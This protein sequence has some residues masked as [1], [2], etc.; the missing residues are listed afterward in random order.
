MTVGVKEYDIHVPY[1]VVDIEN[2]LVRDL[3]EKPVNQFFINAGIYVLAAEL[4]DYVPSNRPFNI[5]ELVQLLVAEGKTVASFPI[6]EYWLDIGRMP[7]YEQAQKDVRNG[8][9]D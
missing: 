5:T 9:L 1:G 7:D 4:L 6:R 8:R 3:S 2:G